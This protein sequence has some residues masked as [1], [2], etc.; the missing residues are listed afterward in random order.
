MNVSW[1]SPAK[2]TPDVS[3]VAAHNR[4]LAPVVPTAGAF[5]SDSH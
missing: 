1:P 5:V 4:A 3:T 2:L